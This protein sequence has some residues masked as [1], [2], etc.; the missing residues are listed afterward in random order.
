MNLVPEGGGLG[1]G[2]R[3]GRLL[4]PAWV[5]EVIAVHRS[6]YPGIFWGRECR[7]WWTGGDKVLIWSPDGR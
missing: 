4:D 2:V 7:Y 6:R 1:A 3:R 5:R